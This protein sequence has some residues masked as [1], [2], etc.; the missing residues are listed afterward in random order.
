[1]SPS[2]LALI[3]IQ[4]FIRPLLNRLIQARREFYLH[5][6]GKV[7]ALKQELSGRF[8]TSLHTNIVECDVRSCESHGAQAGNLLKIVESLNLES[9]SGETAAHNELSFATEDLIVYLNNHIYTSAPF[10]GYGTTFGA[11]LGPSSEDNAKNDMVARVKAEIR[12]VKGAVLNMYTFPD[13]DGL[14]KFRR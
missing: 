3:F 5:S 7:D 10:T 9:N 2:L 4:L 11:G 13:H 14:R 6:L 1:V 8:S 12:S